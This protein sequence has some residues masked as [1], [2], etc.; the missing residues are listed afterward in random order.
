[1]SPDQTPH[2][3]APE[4]G[5]VP[6]TPDSA[7]EIRLLTDADDMVMIGEVFQQVWGSMTE[8][9]R[10][11]MLMAVSHSGGYVVG[12]F[13]TSRHSDSHPNGQ[14]LGASVALLATHHGKP[15]LHSHVTGI[16]P[17]ARST[18]LGRAMKLHQQ[19]WAR[20]RGIE[21]IVWTFDPLVRR[22]AWFNIAILGAEVHEYLPRFYG[23]MTDAINAGDESDR[24]LV[25]WSTATDP[26]A[27]LRDGTGGAA[28]SFIPTP[29]D[30]VALRR[31]DPAAVATWR[32]SSREALT[33]ALDSGRQVVGFTRNGEYVIGS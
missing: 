15:A 27:P 32:A 17:G 21:W 14:I 33:T 28:H 16:L 11:E 10:I 23:T 25:A 29:N 19:S 4:P 3:G 12:A 6:A 5:E 30:I 18:G 24:L 13:D 9:V 31:T 22:N 26:A 8:L 1:M 2:D 7:V 20:A